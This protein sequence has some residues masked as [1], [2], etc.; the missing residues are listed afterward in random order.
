M[1]VAI[2][3]SASPNYNF[4][5]HRMIEEIYAKKLFTIEIGENNGIYY[6]VVRSVAETKQHTAR[7]LSMRLLM[8]ELSHIIRK[9]WIHL[10]RFP[11][12]EPSPIIT[13]E[14]D[15]TYNPRLITPPNGSH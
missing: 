13:L 9:R 15:R 10:R 11:V 1:G 4:A 5:G 8:M 12:P 3:C 7:A 2:L 6:G 14:Q